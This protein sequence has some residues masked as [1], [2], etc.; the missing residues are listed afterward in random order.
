MDCLRINLWSGPR[1]ISTAIMYSFAQRNDTRVIDEPLYGHYLRI[2]G[3][4]HP[5]AQEVMDVMDCDGERVVR[6]VILG[7]C[8]RPVLF[9]KNMAHHLVG[10]GHDF[11]NK[12]C[13]IFLIRDPQEML[14]SLINQIPQPNLRDTAYKTQVN[15]LQELKNFGQ[16]PPVLDAKQLLLN[17]K[18]VLEELCQRIGLSFD[19]RMLSWP[20]GQR[21]EDGVWAPHWYHNVHK[22]TGFQKYQPKT[23]PFPE[24]LHPL[25]DECKPCYESLL[26]DAIKH[27]A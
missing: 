15:L 21:P 10:F 8:D 25:L 23:D 2:T 14:P 13:N 11:L 18:K 3:A 9:I 4:K 22:S 17:P 20:A 12:T 16:I 5:G 19:E 7:E 6:E 1:N 26:K 24:F 27:N